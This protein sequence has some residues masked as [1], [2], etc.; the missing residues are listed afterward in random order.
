MGNLFNDIIK[1][2][3]LFENVT[4]VIITKYMFF[5]IYIV[6]SELIAALHE[7]NQLY[8]KHLNK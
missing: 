8:N 5:Y 3:N 6:I 1:I 2:F 4:C 7:Q